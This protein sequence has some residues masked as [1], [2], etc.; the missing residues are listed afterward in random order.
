MK[1]T[2]YIT[3]MAVLLAAAC[4]KQEISDDSSISALPENAVS[5]TGTICSES[6]SGNN[7]PDTRTVYA[8]GGQS[9]AVNWAEGDGVGIFCST[10]D[11]FT[12]SNVG[13]ETSASGTD[14]A[15]LPLNNGNV[16]VWSDNT[17]PHKFYAYYPYSPASEGTAAD[18]HKVPVSLPSVQMFDSADPFGHLAGIDF[19]YGSSGEVTQSQDDGRVSLDF[20]YLFSVLEVRLCTSLYAA[21]DAVELTCTDGT[22]ALAFDGATMDIEMGTIDV[23][24]AE[25][26]NSIR[27]EGSQNT[28][29]SDY[30]SFYMLISPGHAGKKFNVTAEIG[31]KTYTVVSEK[32][33]PEAGFVAGRTYVLDAGQVQINPEDAEPVTDLSAAGTAN[34]YYVTAPDMLYRFRADVKGNGVDPAGGDVNIV[35][36]SALVL[37]YTC[38]QTNNSPW[39]QESP[40]VIGSLGLEPDGYIYFR[41]PETFVNGNVVVIAIDE[42]LDYSEIQAQDRQI[43]NA[44]VLWS[45]NL[46]V[47]EG[48]D[49]NSVAS[50]F[51][52]GGYTFMSRDLGA[53]IDP[54]QALIG[55]TWN[56]TALAAAIG[57]C[58]QWGRKD[59]FPSLPDVN[60]YIASYTTNLHFT[61]AYTPIPALDLGKFGMTTP[62]RSADHQILGTTDETIC[63][64]VPADVTTPEARI[65]LLTENPH[66]WMTLS[67]EGYLVP[68]D[69]WKAV[70]G[71]PENS[72]IGEKTMYDPCPPGWKVMSKDAWLALTDNLSSTVAKTDGVDGI[73]MDDKYYFPVTGGLWRNNKGYV[74]GYAA[75]CAV[76]AD[77]GYWFDGSQTDKGYG[78]FRTAVNFAN[79]GGDR[80]VSCSIMQTT[81]GTNGASVRCMKIAPGQAIPEGGQLDNF[82]KKDW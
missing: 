48:Y 58:Y 43:T 15:F 69:A 32:P 7:V 82:D 36:K 28:K 49:P 31:G 38:F 53:I 24:G 3:V 78:N 62:D 63:M 13:Y 19:L 22:E 20:N 9:I 33:A 47:T 51:T 70:W 59:P 30:V 52:K 54:G 72:G 23:S 25:T 81:Y 12:A 61:P 45:W 73:L 66:I 11:S 16:I 4:A 68:D 65:G 6:Q 2:L 79:E 27:L 34:S 75:S 14:V 64:T 29:M 56:R 18:I 46:V 77:S 67:G 10:G 80:S 44:N 55:G 17:S 41:T 37:W 40:V 76:A 35:P 21:V 39:L 60:S 57:N 42:D 50:Q 74:S 8:D 5:F 1:Y 26:S 71:N